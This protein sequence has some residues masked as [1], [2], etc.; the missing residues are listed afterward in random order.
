MLDLESL[1]RLETLRVK[2]VVAVVIRW[3]N[4]FATRLE[5]L[6]KPDDA[7]LIGVFGRP[8]EKYIPNY[9]LKHF[10]EVFWCGSRFQE[11]T[12]CST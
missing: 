9:I 3:R 10:N 12:L 1:K 7:G 6:I 4:R 11:K 8:L 2:R 5:N